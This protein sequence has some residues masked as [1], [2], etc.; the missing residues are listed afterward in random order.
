M[1]PATTPLTLPRFLTFYVRGVM[2]VMAVLSGLML[3]VAGAR[4][5]LAADL[6]PEAVINGA[7]LTAG[8]IF[9][10]LSAEKAAYVLGP[11]PKP[12]Q[13]MALNA[14]TLLRVAMALNI[15]WQPASSADQIVIRRAA[16]IIAEDDIR[17]A[18]DVPLQEQGVEGRYDIAFHKGTKPELILPQD[19]APTFDVVGFRYDPSR[20]WF[21]ATV[22]APS[23]DNALAQVAI[24][25]KVQ[26]VV[27]VPI[28]KST[29][30]NGDV[31]GV[32]DIAWVDIYAQD[33]KG[34]LIARA[35]DMIGRT[36]RR[37][38]EAGRPL[39]DIELEQP[40]L[41]SRGDAVTIIYKTPFMTLTAKG[42]SLQGGTK[43]DAVQLV[44]VNSNRTLEGVVSGTR[45]ITVIQ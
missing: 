8:D 43:G 33:V 36:P 37:I 18:L 4:A 15:P 25:G 24:A 32:R 14:S 41:V 23:K 2:T 34:N 38:A 40:S 31:I 12:G 19:V 30:R 28:L 13:D 20:E 44:N 10:G 45:E 29:L 17:A 6:R 16:T 3:I 22:M 11:A 26:R 35:E 27:Q 7:S 9:G 21:Q 39:R 42:K 1:K 5:A